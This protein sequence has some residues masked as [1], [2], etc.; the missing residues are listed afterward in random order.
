M[1]VIVISSEAFKQLKNELVEINKKLDNIHRKQALADAWLDV[2]EACE[3]LKISKRTLQTLR[4]N[5]VIAH[6]KIS[7]K[8]Y[9]KTSDIEEQLNEN[10]VKRKS[11]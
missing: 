7:G 5:R 4:D 10:Y 9:F 8:V 2:S 3:A 1:D 11:Y 6:S